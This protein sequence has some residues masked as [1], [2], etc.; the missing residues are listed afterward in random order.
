MCV[1]LFFVQVQHLWGWHKRVGNKNF[2]QFHVQNSFIMQFGWLSCGCHEEHIELPVLGTFL[3][4]VYLIAVHLHSFYVNCCISNSALK[5]HFLCAV[6]VVAGDAV[7]SRIPRI[8]TAWQMFCMCHFRWEWRN[9]K[10][11]NKCEWKWNESEFYSRIM[12]T[13]PPSPI[14]NSFV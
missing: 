11:K 14:L 13:P 7:E 4:Y 9:K 8:S 12:K 10:K 5:C 6:L 1:I 2:W 3:Y